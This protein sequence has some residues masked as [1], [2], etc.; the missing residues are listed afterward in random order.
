MT[1]VEIRPIDKNDI[2]WVISVLK[3]RWGSTKII[4]KGKAHQADQLPGYIALLDKKKKGVIT[5][6]IENDCEIVTLDCLSQGRGVGTALVKRVK[7]TARKQGCKR[8]WLIT[9]NDNTDALHFYQ[10]RGFILSAL[11]PNALKQSRKLK[12][13]I[14]QTGI[15]GIPLRDEI[16]LEFML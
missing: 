8:V 2:K 16:E 13:E 12:P 11:Y 3:R 10:K 7:E 4:T 14:P 5:Y 6:S 1:E 9:T 15:D